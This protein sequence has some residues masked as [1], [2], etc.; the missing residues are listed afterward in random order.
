MVDEGAIKVDLDDEV[1]AGSLLT[2]DGRIIH[3]PTAEK[4]QEV[5]Q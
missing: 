2:H 4:L 5:V 3:Q 1:V